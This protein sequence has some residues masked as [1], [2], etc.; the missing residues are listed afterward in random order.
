MHHGKKKP[1]FSISFSPR[2][3]TTRSTTD[4]Y[5]TCI[6]SMVFQCKHAKMSS[7]RKNKTWDKTKGKKKLKVSTF[8][9]LISYVY[10]ITRDLLHYA[11]EN[12]A[13]RPGTVFL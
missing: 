11:S 12:N 10:I 9:I 2:I 7:S 13:P 6:I 5:S 8:L 4:P 3:A 1:S